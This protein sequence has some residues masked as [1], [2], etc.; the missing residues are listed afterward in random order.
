MDA[1]NSRERRSISVRKLPLKRI[2]EKRTE[3]LFMKRVRG[4][5]S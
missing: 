5:E 4:K 2:L 1:E 3:K